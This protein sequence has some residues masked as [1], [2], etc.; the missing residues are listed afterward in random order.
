M[1]KAFNLGLLVPEHSRAHGYHDVLYGSRQAGKQ[2][3]QWSRGRE[4]TPYSQV[5]GRETGR[6][7]G[8]GRGREN[9]NLMDGLPNLEAYFQ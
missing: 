9:A 7:T 5:Q 4:L 1:N 8:R 2:A 3:C 6:R